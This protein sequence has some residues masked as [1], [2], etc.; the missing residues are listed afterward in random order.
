MDDIE[1]EK[2]RAEIVHLNANT[3]RIQQQMQWQMPVYLVSFLAAIVA[4]VRLL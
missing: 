1:I 2:I 4:A 3:A